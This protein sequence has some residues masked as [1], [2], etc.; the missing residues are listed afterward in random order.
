MVTR[1]H[2]NSDDGVLCYDPTLYRSIVGALQNLTFTRPDIEYA[3][4][5]VYQFMHQPL[6]C[7][8]KTVKRILRYLRGTLNYGLDIHGGSI[9]SLLIYSDADWAGC[10]STRCSTTGF[11][12]FL[13]STMVSWSSKKQATVSHSSAK[14][15]YRDVAHSVAELDWLMSLLSE[16]GISFPS[17]LMV[18]CDNISVLNVSYVPT[19]DQLADFFTKSLSS[20]RFHSLCSN[21]EIGDPP[22]SIA[23]G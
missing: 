2:L 5:Q 1:A 19:H 4:N 22:A 3:I 13:G 16:L 9:P 11:C 12:L 23:G 14:A 17:L 10:P 18:L 21:L 8:F 6:D 7:H 15:E 20:D